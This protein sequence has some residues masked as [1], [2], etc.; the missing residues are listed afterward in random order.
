[1]SYEV[2]DNYLD[3]EIFKSI[4]SVFI[5]NY[6]FLGIIMMG[7]PKKNQIKIDTSFNLYIC[8][9]E[10]IKASLQTIISTLYH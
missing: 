9:L 5:N 10:K 2:F 1:M 4:Q 6:N 7:L 8:Y 3:D